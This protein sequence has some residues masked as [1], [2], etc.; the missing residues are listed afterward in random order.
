MAGGGDNQQT[1]V[2]PHHANTSERGIDS[3]ATVINI[4]LNN[5]AI[6][7]VSRSIVEPQMG[8]PFVFA[9]TTAVETEVSL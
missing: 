5:R 4:L 9:N 6:E 1:I 7:F 8:V 3:L 2:E